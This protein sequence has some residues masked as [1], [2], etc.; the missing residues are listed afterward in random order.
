MEP[1]HKPVHF[2]LPEKKIFKSGEVAP[3]SGNY[4]FEKHDAEVPNCVPRLGV[5]LHLLKGMKIP[6]HDDC[7]QPSVYSLMTVTEEDPEAMLKR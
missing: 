2:R 1:S 7:L 5:Y 6:L 3:V 4:R